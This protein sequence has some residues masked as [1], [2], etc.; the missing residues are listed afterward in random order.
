MNRLLPWLAAGCATLAVLSAPWALQA[1][2]MNVVFKPLATALIMAWAWPRGMGDPARRWVLA[3]LALSWAG[4]VALL[5]QQQG[6]LPG[7]VSFLAA[8]ACYLVAFTRGTRWLA[9]WPAAVLYGGLAATVLAALWPGIPAGLGGP[10]AVYVLALATMSAQA[11]SQWQAR[12]GTLRA[13]A[14]ARA[15]A[16][17]A[18]FMLSDALLATDRF[19][20]PLPAASLWILASYWLAQGL[21]ASSLA[22]RAVPR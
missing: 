20:A 16:G 10:V 7:L 21:I 12:V 15:A 5:W 19:A 14:A 2:W 11:A 4:D 1:A 8:H 3:G 13:G 9:W 22:P 18:L 17:G 6:F